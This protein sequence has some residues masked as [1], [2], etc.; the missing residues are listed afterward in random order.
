[1]SHHDPLDLADAEIL[2]LKEDVEMLSAALAPFAHCYNF[3]KAYEE[4]GDISPIDDNTRIV[5][6]VGS[7]SSFYLDARAFREAAEAMFGME[8]DGEEVGF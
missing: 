6:V 5:H 7:G 1:M 3:L 2:R 4:T 8:D